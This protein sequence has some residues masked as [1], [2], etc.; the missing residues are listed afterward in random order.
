MIKVEDGVTD[1]YF[2]VQKRIGELARSVGRDPMDI[3]LIA[4]TKTVPIDPIKHVFEAGCFDFGENRI[5]EALKKIPYLPSTIRWHFIGTLQSN[6]VNKA[7]STFHL[8]HSVDTPDLARKISKASQEKGVTTSILLQVN[9]SQELSKHGLTG[10]EWRAYLKE[11]D[12]LPAIQLNG[13]MTIAPLVEDQALIQRC[14]RQLRLLREEFRQELKDPKIFH[15]LSMGM[16][17]DYPLAIAEG[18]TLVRI[19]SAIFGDRQMK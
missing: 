11:M 19:G 9:T 14:F 1:H 18:A 13:L 7:I 12:Q 2:S 8:I 4:V 6:K 3:Q 5:Q 17:H 16:S 15:H 10:E